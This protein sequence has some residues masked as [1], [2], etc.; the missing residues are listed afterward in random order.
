MN[1]N[2]MQ[3]QHDYWERWTDLSRKAWGL[4]AADKPKADAWEA[5]MDHWWQALAPA[6][7]DA[8]R[9]FMA[10]L[11]DQ[12]K[13]FFRMTDGFTRNLTGEGA[14]APG[15]DAVS[16]VL[17]DMQKGFGDGLT[18]GDDALHTMLAFWELPYDNWQRMM[19]SLSPVPGDLL[20]NMP[21]EQIKEG[22]NRVLSAPGLGYTREEQWQYQ[23]LLR[24][25]LTYQQALQE[26]FGFFSHLGVKSTER[27]R[28]T[29]EN[30]VKEG[31]SI[32]S[33]RDLYDTWVS[34]CE[35]VYGEEV[36][37]A[38]YARIH[39]GLVNAQMALKQR[40]SIVV[41][42]ALGAM[43]MPTRSE[44]CTL[45]DRLQ[46]SR[47]EVKTLRHELD[48][49]RREMHAL[50]ERAGDSIAKEEADQDEHLT[51]TEPLAPP[52]EKPPARKKTTAHRDQK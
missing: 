50:T 45:Q 1:D 17:A 39:G 5:A 32:G 11:V 30:L 14:A 4:E 33:A 35:E 18:Q 9:G 52:S 10:K 29:M 47:R 28:Q 19:S 42:E 7:P 3:L 37:T 31:K 36:R 20:R 51:A 25:T 49:L 44:L 41:D 8:A 22:L 6:A 23:D 16:K 15:W 46:A 2:W 27:M 34:C 21:H 12:G 13:M 38:E 26:Y 48:G 24:R 40:M 43:N